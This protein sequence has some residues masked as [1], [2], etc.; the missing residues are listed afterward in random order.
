MASDTKMV[1]CDRNL[2]VI[3]EFEGVS[4]EEVRCFGASKRAVFGTCAG[5]KLTV[6]DFTKL[7]N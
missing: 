2:K 7:A 3:R 4:I 5:G 6:W 1:L